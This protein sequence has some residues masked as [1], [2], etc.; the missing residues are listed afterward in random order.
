MKDKLILGQS[1][2]TLGARIITAYLAAYPDFV[3]PADGTDTKSHRELHSFFRDMICTISQ[4]PE[5]I[6]IAAEPDR[7]FAERWLLNNSN[8][9]LMD[10]M[11]K[12]EKK[13]FDW[14]S[15]LHKL[16]ALGEVK[17]G[18]LL[19][20]KDAWKLP[21]KMLDKLQ[22][23]GLQSE[24]APEGVLL[25]CE[26]YPSIFPAWKKR[27]IATPTQD[28]QI[29]FLTHFLFGT[30]PGRPYRATEMFG[31]LYGDPKWL[32]ELESFFEKLGYTLSNDER[33][34]QVRWEKEYQGKEHGYLH[35]AYRFRDR[36]QMCF[37]FRVP[38]F[39]LL[40]NH[41]HEMEY[42]LGELCFTRTK[43]CDNCGYCTQTDKSG[44]RKKLALP[45]KYP[46]GEML[47]C[48]LWPWFTW[49][50]LDEKTIAK[51]EKLFLFAEEKLY[52]RTN[53]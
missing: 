45:I 17:D 25:R 40:M 47:K 15:T 18:G 44:Q 53:K 11:I 6:G 51:V 1:F 48:P 13:F 34:L 19:I 22:L 8:P 20:P 42:E 14:V 37:E 41:Y 27:S 23:F 32:I 4:N 29:P 12:I 7:C 24:A 3:P 50:E 33:G 2:P 36:L 35:I 9:E 21:V 38:S 46:G 26:R 28:G 16:G 39:R 52:G 49:N 43:V 5:W 10:A 31:K 30:Q